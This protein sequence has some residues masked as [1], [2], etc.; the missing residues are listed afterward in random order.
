MDLRL[1]AC[2][3]ESQS[4]QEG[5]GG[6]QPAIAGLSAVAEMLKRSWFTRL[7][8]VQEAACKQAV[9]QGQ[10]RVRLRCGPL[11]MDNM[12]L[13]ITVNPFLVAAS[14]R[15]KAGLLS[16]THD[17][18]SA[19]ARNWESA[20]GFF[21]AIGGASTALPYVILKNVLGLSERRCYDPRDRLFAVYSLFRLDE[22]DGLRPDYELP[23][24]A[25]Y[26]RLVRACMAREDQRERNGSQRPW[27]WLAL[28][29]TEGPG[30]GN[31]PRPSWVPHLHYFTDTTRKKGEIYMEDRY[32]PWTQFGCAPD[33][34]QCRSLPS[35]R[36]MIQLRAKCYAE[37]IETSSVFAWPPHIDGDGVDAHIGHLQWYEQCQEFLGMIPAEG[38]E[39]FE[40]MR[41]LSCG[42]LHQLPAGQADHLEDVADT[43]FVGLWKGFGAM[44]SIMRGLVKDSIPCL[45]R[46]EVENLAHKDGR[47][48]RL[49]GL[50]P[51]ATNDVGW[52]PAETIVGDI[53]CLVAGA[54]YPFVLRPTTTGDQDEFRLLGD[55]YTVNMTLRAAL[56][57][58]DHEPRADI[59]INPSMEWNNR[60][61]EDFSK[62]I[63][64]MGWVTLR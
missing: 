30:E 15:E 34:F 57:L 20:L 53:L 48:C 31:D 6:L 56:R 27:T 21:G 49:R 26:T 39:D 19:V 36:T 37:V 45:C 7:W 46:D 44:A 38:W 35:D 28:V 54:P 5:P 50:R 32:K 43:H 17:C 52:L 3:S 23:A 18:P 64:N 25:L 61:D 63:S 60:S 29:G 12:A 8:V 2:A 42:W 22:L 4:G 62:A 40:T 1:G 10:G 16:G 47:L 58:T 33:L 59:L 24:G 41:L 9:G 13:R 55:A 51:S 11:D 14:T